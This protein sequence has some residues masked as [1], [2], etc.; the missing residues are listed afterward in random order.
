MLKK[1]KQSKKVKGGFLNDAI[2]PLTLVAIN[3]WFGKRSVK[4]NKV[5]SKTLKNKK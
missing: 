2:V 3:N 1:Q 5:K 4:N